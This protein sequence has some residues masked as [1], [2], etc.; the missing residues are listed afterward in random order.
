MAASNK[1]SPFSVASERFAT[2]LRTVSVENTQTARRDTR[3]PRFNADDHTLWARTFESQ[4]RRFLCKT[5]NST[6]FH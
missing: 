5:T 3:R 4:W 1:Q 2:V 6:T